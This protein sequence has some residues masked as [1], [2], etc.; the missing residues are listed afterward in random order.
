[1]ADF[2]AFGSSALL[3]LVGPA[4]ENSA[5]EMRYSGTAL[6]ADITAYTSLAEDYCLRGAEGVEQLARFI[7]LAFRRYIGCV[8]AAGGA[9]AG[10]AGDALLAFWPE[11]RDGRGSDL[12]SAMQCARTLHNASIVGLPEPA[13]QRTLHIGIASGELWAA[14]VGG[15]DDR[16]HLLLAG[17]T[18]T[19]ASQCAIDAASGKTVLSP[20]ARRVV[21]RLSLA[22]GDIVNSIETDDSA[23]DQR[24]DAG[25]PQSISSAL[26]SGLPQFRTICAL[27]LRIDG[28]ALAA[29]NSLARLQAA[30]STAMSTLRPYSVS[31]GSLVYDDKGLVLRV[32]L[33]LPQDAYV[34]DPVRAV[35]AGL[36]IERELE[37]IGLSAACGVASGKG[38]CM[39]PGTIDRQSYVAVGRFM[40]I[41]ARLMQQAGEGLLC[42]DEIADRIRGD[43]TLSPEGRIRLKGIRRSI[44][45]FRALAKHRAPVKPDRLFGREFERR[46]LDAQLNALSQGKGRV[47]SI[48]G[49]AG[50]G[51][52]ALVRDFV[53]KARERGYECLVGGA[54]SVDTA[55]PYLAWR[56][57][58]SR[59]LDSDTENPDSI[60]TLL[61][62]KLKHPKLAPLVNL[63]VPGFFEDSYHARDLSG[64]ARAD[65]IVRLL[66]EVITLLS[67][68]PMILVLEDCHWMDSASWRLLQRVAVDNPAALI[69]L[70]SRPQIQRQELDG[71]KS[72]RNYLELP[73]SPLRREAVAQLVTHL[74][75]EDTPS[76]DLVNDIVER[77]ACNPLFIHEFTLLLDSSRRNRPSHTSASF[78]ELHWKRME[79]LPE[80]VEGLIASRLDALTPEEN[81]VLKSA[82]VLGDQFPTEL[83]ARMHDEHS[84]G[85]DLGTILTN[86]VEH[87]VLVEVGALGRLLEFRH[88]LIR[89]GAYEQLTVTQRRKLH[90]SAAEAIESC[91]PD[92]LDAFVASLAHHW[93]VADV[94]ERAI[95]YGD[96]AANHALGAGAYLEADRLLQACLE[97]D[98][99]LDRKLVSHETTIRW[100]RQCADARRG[101][102]QLES[103]AAAAREALARANCHRFNNR[104]ALSAQ[105]SLSALMLTKSRLMPRRKPRPVSS[106]TLEIAQAYRHSAEV[107]YFD[108]DMIGMICDSIS[109]VQR[110]EAAPP[111][112]VL[113]SAS[114]ELGGVLAIAGFTRIGEA[115]LRHAI[116]V[117][118]RAGD[119]GALAYAHLVSSLYSVGTGDWTNA[120]RSAR[121]CQ[122]LCDPMDDAVNWTNAEAIRFWIAHYQGQLETAEQSAQRLQD[123]ARQTGNRQHQA[124]SLRYLAQCALR[125]ND[126]ETATRL[127]TSALDYLGETAAL[128]ERI[129]AIALLALSML[130]SGSTWGARAKAGDGIRL[131]SQIKRPIGHG[132]LEGYSALADVVFDAWQ[133]EPAASNWKQDARICLRVLR[134]YRAAFPIGAARF[135][136]W[137]G[138]YLELCGRRIGARTHFHRGC[139]S[140]AEFDM[141][142]DESRCREAIGGS[143]A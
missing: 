113:A 99:R 122:Q 47:L 137:K 90:R 3:E 86:L 136:F 79:T 16:W 18:V 60:K 129:P 32:A 130:K 83:L 114:T 61:L 68:K 120:D 139:R 50:I 132:A 1:M 64:D 13:A 54:T 81:L 15:V 87:E 89:Q 85:T 56:P 10:V 126:P 24:A 17:D 63:V 2:R 135:H 65:A 118:A 12:S 107:C 44:Q 143:A 20:T 101:T 74:L 92:D 53:S 115:I 94:P 102:G 46:Q 29:P 48:V 4:D 42:T 131:I 58:I 106:L 100:F 40:H 57:I 76:P 134:K 41:A 108:N 62:E 49:Q 31:P 36:A 51:K 71:L 26:E 38:I 121:F 109:S 95:E 30:V 119:Q 7:D 77:S 69:L 37:R 33:G 123:R 104:L 52:T 27:F 140:A 142:W 127:L 70:T 22:E 97:L 45:A 35:S 14:R 138:R 39:P 67:P 116:D 23:S 103:R 105:A 80:T 111:S 5:A 98:R 43:F 110:A 19:A 91:Y 93:F 75:D 72:L 133:N 82:S 21:E 125:R 11:Q 117:A 96:R 73:L 59:I 6:F 55:V 141:V 78:R 8:H 34:N 25:R 124:W 88:S 9:V 66:S 28:I 112:T 128:N 84:T